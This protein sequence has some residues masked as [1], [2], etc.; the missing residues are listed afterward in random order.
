MSAP[1]TTSAPAPL[2][3]PADPRLGRFV[4]H[5]LMTTD[6]AA[7]RPFYAALLGWACVPREVGDFEYTDVRAAGAR[8]GGMVPLDAS[9]GLPSHWASYVAVDDV[10]AAC[11]RAEAAGGRVCVPPHDVPGGAGQFAVLNDPAGAMLS[12]VRFA[13]PFA[14]PPNDAAGG[15]WWHELFSTDPER[16]A[17]F[18]AAVFGWSAAPPTTLPSGTTY[19]ILSADGETV[20]GV[21]RTPRE[22]GDASWWQLYVT[23]PDVDAAVARAAELGG[24]PTWPAM[25]VPGVGRMAGLV[26]NTGARFAVGV[27]APAAGPPA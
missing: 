5:D 17:A 18:L 2:A 16:S 27:S 13:E 1:H 3:P 14:T 12:V 20:C 21:M 11:A 8:F 15:A 6:P 22:M 10:A 4:Y 7:A 19:R 9:H 26:D 25:D 24:A 23:V